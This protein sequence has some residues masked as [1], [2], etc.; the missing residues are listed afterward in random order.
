MTVLIESEVGADGI[1]LLRLNRPDKLNAI[2]QEMITQWIAA[3]RRAGDDDGV[4]V[5]ILT[6]A[7]RA[8][9][10]GGDL[11]EAQRGQPEGGPGMKKFVSHIQ[12][13][14]LILERFD[15]PVIAAINGTARGAGLD[16]A[17]MC[18]IRLAARSAMLAESYINLGLIAGDGGTYFLPRL[19]GTAR[20]LEMFWTGDPVTAEEAE[21]IGMINRAVPDADL[22]AEARKLALRIAAQPPQAIR[23]FKRAV[24]QSMQS[25]LA[26]HLDMVGSHMGVLSETPEHKALLSAFLTRK[27]K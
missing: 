22:M 14:P 27:D 20:A 21:R 16:M 26:T 10:V 8:F 12:Q 9:C 15:K 5:V 24:Y 25:P 4:K 11:A 2:S 3:L 13:I 7:G 6:G 23:M 19:I 18:D 1:M 17:L